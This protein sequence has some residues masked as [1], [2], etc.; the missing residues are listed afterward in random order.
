MS[1]H[2]PPPL[3]PPLPA[4][5]RSLNDGDLQHPMELNE[6]MTELGSIMQLPRKTTVQMRSVA[7]PARRA[8]RRIPWLP[9]L[10][11]VAMAALGLWRA[12]PSGAPS[13]LPLELVGE[14]RTSD[15]RY[16]ERRLAFSPSG[17]GIIL[18]QGQAATWHEVESVVTTPRGDTTSYDVQYRDAGSSV[19]FLV[20]RVTRP[21]PR[22]LLSNPPG[23]VWEPAAGAR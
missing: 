21:G 19:R 15:P 22:L 7:E 5:V 8:P 18:Q 17:V 14:W 20:H 6:F 13:V 11:V 1:R 16:V 2:T 12:W 23:V 10:A 3:D 9:A 4:A